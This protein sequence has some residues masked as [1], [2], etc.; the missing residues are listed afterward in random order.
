MVWA[1]VLESGGIREVGM[2]RQGGSFHSE[3]NRGH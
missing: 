1:N 3:D 2:R